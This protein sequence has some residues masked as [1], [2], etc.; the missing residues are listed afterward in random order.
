MRGV[1]A[2]H[3]SCKRVHYAQRMGVEGNCPGKVGKE[4][5]GGGQSR[6]AYDSIGAG[7]PWRSG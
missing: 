7:T 4:K 2:M 5:Q 3:E 1:N 6:T